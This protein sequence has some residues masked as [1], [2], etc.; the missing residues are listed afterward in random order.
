MCLGKFKKGK[1]ICNCRWGREKHEAK[2]TQYTVFVYF[3]IT[4]AGWKNIRSN[5]N[6]TLKI[7]T[8]TPFIFVCYK[9]LLNH[10]RIKHFYIFTVCCCTFIDC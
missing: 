10:N 8:E 3:L 4:V 6:K 7:V 2:I 9:E 5:G 1:V